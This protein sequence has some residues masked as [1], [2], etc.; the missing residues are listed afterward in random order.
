MRCMF[1]E[2][3]AMEHFRSLLNFAQVYFK[4]KF[5]SVWKCSYLHT[6][7]LNGQLHKTGTSLKRTPGFGP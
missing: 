4:K 5:K 7:P 2:H 3:Q 1:A 6:V